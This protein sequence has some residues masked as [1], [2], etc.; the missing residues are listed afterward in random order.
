[1]KTLIRTGTLSLTGSEFSLNQGTG[2]Y[3]SNLPQNSTLYNCTFVQNSGDNGGA[4]HISSSQTSVLNITFGNF[5]ENSA[6]NGGGLWVT[7]PVTISVN[8]TSLYNNTVNNNGG[9]MYLNLDSK[10]SLMIYNGQIVNNSANIGGGIYGANIATTS[11]YNGVVSQNIAVSQGNYPRIFADYVIDFAKVLLY[12]CNNLVHLQRACLVQLWTKICHLME[13]C[14]SRVIPI[15]PYVTR[16]S[17]EIS[18]VWWD[19]PRVWH[20]SF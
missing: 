13:H 5:S 19:S 4:V 17:P 10:S 9:S 8:D 6:T 20:L 1:M 16:I 7:G 11:I 12:L 3:V 15:Y 2:L 14:T 18:G